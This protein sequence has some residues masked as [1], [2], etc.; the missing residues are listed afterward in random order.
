MTS[1]KYSF[2]LCVLPHIWEEHSIRTKQPVHTP[3]N[4]WYGA[5]TGFSD[6]NQ[7]H[8]LGSQ[9]T[10]QSAMVF[11]SPGSH[12]LNAVTGQ[13]EDL[14]AVLEAGCRKTAVRNDLQGNV[15]C[16]NDIYAC[17]AHIFNHNVADADRCGGFDMID[18]VHAGK[19]LFLG[20]VA[21]GLDAAAFLIPACDNDSRG[22]CALG[23]SDLLA[24]IFIADRAGVACHAE[25]FFA[26]KFHSDLAAHG[27]ADARKILFFHN[28]FSPNPL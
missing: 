8:Y 11:P 5:C 1:A 12:C 24:G 3:F 22:D 6:L 9:L 4:L 7:N 2:R 23:V 27:A 17:A 13:L 25:D 19:D 21:F 26:F 18:C 14:P 10:E 20:D 28:L 16:G 15:F